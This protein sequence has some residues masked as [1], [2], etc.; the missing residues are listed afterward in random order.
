[1]SVEELTAGMFVDIYYNG[2]I[3]YEKN[4]YGTLCIYSPDEEWL[5]RTLTGADKTALEKK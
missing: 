1:M 5:N 4:A 3:D 2:D